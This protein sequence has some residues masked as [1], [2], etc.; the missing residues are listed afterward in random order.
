[1]VKSDHFSNII[2][3]ID[4]TSLVKEQNQSRKNLITE[5]NNIVQKSDEIKSQNE[6][7]EIVNYLDQLIY[8]AGFSK[9]HSLS[10]PN[11]E[12]MRKKIHLQILDK[13]GNGIQ[14][15]NIYAKKQIY[16]QK[17]IAMI[18]EALKINHDQS[19]EKALH[20]FN[21]IIKKNME[22]INKGLGEFANFEKEYIEERL[23]KYIDGID[24]FKKAKEPDLENIEITDT[25]Y[26][27]IKKILTKYV[28]ESLKINIENLYH[29]NFLNN[30]NLEDQISIFA[31]HVLQQYVGA[32]SHAKNACE[33][34]EFINVYKKNLI[35]DIQTND[36]NP[37]YISRTTNNNKQILHFAMSDE[38]ISD[39][40]KK[41]DII[42]NNLVKTSLLN[43]MDEYFLRPNINHSLNMSRKLDNDLDYFLNELNTLTKELT[44]YE[45]KL[46]IFH[47][48]PRS[49][50]QSLL[51][52]IL[53]DFIFD[54]E[55]HHYQ[56]DTFLKTGI[57][58]L[59]ECLYQARHANCDEDILFNF[60]YA[61]RDIIDQNGVNLF[62]K[63]CDQKKTNDEQLNILAKGLNNFLDEINSVKV[64]YIPNKS[65]LDMQNKFFVKPNSS[66]EKMFLSSNDYL[67]R[68]WQLITPFI[69]NETD[70]SNAQNN[71]NNL[72]IGCKQLAFAA[73]LGSNEA[74]NELSL[75]SC[76]KLTTKK[77]LLAAD[78]KFYHFLKA[79][80][81]TSIHYNDVQKN[82]ALYYYGLK[83][84]KIYDNY[85]DR[86][87]DILLAMTHLRNVDASSLTN[88]NFL[89]FLKHAFLLN[90]DKFTQEEIENNAFRI[91][92]DELLG[93]D[94][95]R[96]TLDEAASVETK[97]EPTYPFRL[98]KD[99]LHNLLS[100][101]LKDTETKN[102]IKNEVLHNIDKTINSKIET[103]SARKINYSSY[104]ICINSDS[105][106]NSASKVI[107]FLDPETS[108]E[109]AR[110]I[111][112]DKG[113][114][115]DCFN[116]DVKFKI[117]GTLEGDNFEIENVKT[118]L[119]LEVNLKSGKNLCFTTNAP[120]MVFDGE[121]NCDSLQINCQDAIL[122]KNA[123]FAVNSLININGKELSIE[124]K[125]N[126]N[127]CF[128][129][130]SGS[131]TQSSTSTIHAYN[132]INV[133]ALSLKGIE[134]KIDAENK[135]N[136]IADSCVYLKRS[137][138]LKAKEH[139][140]IQATSMLTT[141]ESKLIAE[142][143]L[144]LKAKDKIIADEL[145]N[146]IAESLVVDAKTI[147]NFSPNL[148]FANAD[149]HFENEFRNFS[150]GIFNTKNYLKLSGG[151]VWNGGQIKYGENLYAN[152]NRVFVHG[153]SSLHSTSYDDHHEEGYWDCLKNK[154][155]SNGS[156]ISGK[157]AVIVAGAYINILGLLT[158][159]DFTFTGLGEINFGAAASLNSNKNALISLD[160]GA[161]VPNIKAYATEIAQFIEDVNNGEYE[162]VLSSICN[163]NNLYKL[164]SC[165]KWFI[166]SIFPAL[167][168]PIN[169][170][171]SLLI[172]I[173]NAPN[174]FK[175]IYYLYQQKENLQ[176]SQIYELV[177]MINAVT[178]HS[179]LLGSELKN[180][181]NFEFDYTPNFK[182]APN[183][184]LNF[185]SLFL[186]SAT[187]Q[188]L[189]D[190][191]LGSFNLSGNIQNNNLF[192][193]SLWDAEIA[194]TIANMFYD[195]HLK[196]KLD[197]A[198]LLSNSGENLTKS[199]LAITANDIS[200]V[201]NR[202]DSGHI[203]T[204]NMIWKG[205]ELELKEKSNIDTKDAILS[206]NKLK[207]SGTVNAD[208][209][210][211]VGEH[212]MKV[213]GDINIKQDKNHVNTN[214]DHSNDKLI[215]PE[216]ILSAPNIQQNKN[217]H[218][219]AQK[220]TTFL[221]SQNAR[222]SGENNTELYANVK[223]ELN[224]DGKFT[225]PGLHVSADK[226]VINGDITIP[227][228]KFDEANRN[229]EIQP[230]ITI[231]GNELDISQ[232]TT[233]K[234]PDST[235]V[236]DEQ[237]ISA[238]GNINTSKIYS[239]GNRFQKYS[240]SLLVDEM[241]V[242]GD[243]INSEADIHF[244]H[245]N[246]EH[247]FSADA[248]SIFQMTQGSIEGDGTVAIK[249][250]DA[251]L[252][253]I[254]VNNLAFEFDHIDNI[255]NLITCSGDYS[256]LHPRKGIFIA[257]TDHVDLKKDFDLPYSATIAA[258][259][260]D[261]T[262]NIHSSG[263]LGFI[264]KNKDIKTTQNQINADG[265]IYIDSHGKYIN[266]KGD[267][268][269]GEL[270]IHTQDDA[271]NNAGIWRS[272]LYVEIN[273]DQGNIINRCYEHDVQGKY[274]VVKA[275]EP[276][277]IFGG[278]GNNHA[279]V[280]LNMHAGNKIV[281]DASVI[282][283]LGDNSI[284]GDKGIE[285]FARY[286][287]YLSYYKHW[288]NIWREKTTKEYSTQIQPA[289]IS[290]LQGKN[291]LIS[292]DG[293]IH[294]VS[295]DFF[296]PLGHDLYAK[297]DIV[298]EGIIASTECDK[299]Q[300]G[301]F[302]ITH[303]NTKQYDEYAV[304]T[305]MVDLADSRIV[306]NSDIKIT[307]AFISGPGDLYL[308]GK[309]VFISSPILNHSFKEDK[310][311]FGIKL[312]TL[313]SIPGYSIYKDIDS[314]LSAKHVGILTNMWNTGVDAVLAANNAIN[315][316]RTGNVS[317]YGSS[318]LPELTLTHSK[319][320]INE[321]SVAE[322]VG[323]YKDSLHI[324]ADDNV[325][326][327]NG[328]TV[329]IKN[330]ASIKSKNFLQSG[331]QLQ[332]SFTSDSQEL[333]FG[334]SL[335]GEPHIGANVSGT[336]VEGKSY[337]NQSF[338][339]GNQLSIDVDNW[340]M[341]AAN[342]NSKCIAGKVGKFTITSPL[343]TSSSESYGAHFDTL[344]SMGANYSTDSKGWIGI[345]SGLNV[346]DG[347]NI[348]GDDFN[349][350]HLILE[351][352]KIM[353]DGVNNFH[354]D[355][356][357]A[358]DVKGYDERFSFGFDF[359]ANDFIN[360]GNNH[361][362][363]YN[364]N[365]GYKDYQDRQLGTIFGKQGTHIN[366]NSIMGNIISDNGEGIKIDK[367]VDMDINIKIPAFNKKNITAMQDNFDWLLGRDNEPIIHHSIDTKKVDTEKAKI[368]PKS[369]VKDESEKNNDVV[370]NQF[371][372]EELS[373]AVDEINS[374][375]F[376]L[377]HKADDMVNDLSET[378]SEFR[379]EQQDEEQFRQEVDDAIHMP[380]P[381]VKLRLDDANFFKPSSYNFF[382]CNDKNNSDWSQFDYDL[383]HSYG[384]AKAN[385]YH[386]NESYITE[387]YNDASIS[388]ELNVDFA[389]SRYLFHPSYE[390]N[391]TFTLPQY[392]PY[393]WLTTKELGNVPIY[394]VN[395]E[396]LLDSIYMGQGA[397]TTSWGQVINNNFW[398]T[399]DM[400]NSFG[401]GFGEALFFPVLYPKETIEG[402]FVLGQ[403]NNDMMMSVIDEEAR[404]RVVEAG[405]LL[406]KSAKDFRAELFSDDKNE[407]YKAC[408]TA[409]GNIIP[410][411]GL[412][413]KAGLFGKIGKAGRLV[414]EEGVANL[415]SK[416]HISG[417]RLQQQL[418][419]EEASSIFNES[420]FL[421]KEAIDSAKI[422]AR[423]D[424]LGNEELVN[425]LLQKEGNLSDWG[426]YRTP[427]ID[428]PSGRFEMHFYKNS[429]T[430]E[431][432]YERDYKAVFEHQG[433]WN[434]EPTPNFDYEP[435]RYNK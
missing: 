331:A 26:S 40:Y 337:Q 230:E 120:K 431:V 308:A 27:Y 46:A 218:I 75:N 117:K 68:Y 14:I 62:L 334:I 266:E 159:N 9:T 158:L 346:K 232:G 261:I 79:C 265:V 45:L 397:T 289:I 424:K 63:L 329:D 125:L 104:A 34:Q 229:K 147:K 134:G 105:I 149:L 330:D 281:N 192:S 338:N 102:K 363:I 191:R 390:Q 298:L 352:G 411:G 364:V 60:N 194:L 241:T 321:Q 288:K 92:L 318:L 197:I 409:A 170:L 277:C 345:P 188:A 12:L 30:D 292:N 223:N 166:G 177:G 324:V 50:A 368:N 174:I 326:F 290:S 405:K 185:A 259:S 5:I 43:K 418:K 316:A 304:P 115:I 6:L 416:N 293:G 213:E 323:I 126:S 67:M 172:I 54:I 415:A 224:L 138:R 98:S 3:H 284:S 246:Q 99:K 340:E 52:K 365:F 263:S 248:N 386:P 15:F 401:K 379:R 315:I 123:K 175:Q 49:E 90:N 391:N 140:A 142:K 413:A 426:K 310:L 182:N 367:D 274:D 243:V 320:K 389:N 347:I 164:A 130:L 325:E 254:N 111:K 403:L 419:M 48:K 253:H 38:C 257:T 106:K 269:G 24:I 434:L 28:N 156:C 237:N 242:K 361:I 58:Y 384:R 200:N 61:N 11:V 72:L 429:V 42:E 168:K 128:I 303:D 322:N 207:L 109:V 206:Q 233:I 122:E 152:L 309:N 350:G 332:H 186:P 404:Q 211:A 203:I 121:I 342:T 328:C 96:E 209:F 272:P 376:D 408:G 91:L 32:L 228:T 71:I 73:L 55:P 381:D 216:L 145:S 295:T 85:L 112:E 262:A 349:V 173:S 195:D 4:V 372:D 275:Y 77:A 307:N 402:I 339:V 336:N 302:G 396:N 423:G 21:Q 356:I 301:W 25:E 76:E 148:Y 93:E 17:C 202:K 297:N 2:P 306:S 256:D 143:A 255:D 369:K 219:N 132:D 47:F 205:D 165:I 162:K 278:S 74:K 226:T 380:L 388:P 23:M 227:E 66:E 296:A 217:S 220:A 88:D 244:K 312:P 247:Y 153:I 201:N 375:D 252:G 20:D 139:L 271:V 371:E 212:D 410:I 204:K 181:R 373:K 37:D 294:S 398:D 154:V 327:K 387:Q 187:K 81:E 383:S 433:R 160:L 407:R 7:D 236:I 208:H 69:K 428:S 357:E 198:Y 97:S 110:I 264:S 171:W 59:V 358:K 87:N 270:Y 282:Y 250:P 300:T 31:A 169:M 146:W 51:R 377:S 258:D 299:K 64:L 335:D 348:N 317:S 82:L 370:I 33:L 382:G 313:E 305:Y 80:P 163:H 44:W 65:K 394:D 374:F 176:P 399:I 136:V 101:A 103:Y 378:N 70:K 412:L 155:N 430:G 311:D 414:G 133:K 56:K 89:K 116:N 351:G 135:L 1:M 231:F 16:L 286:H 366:T 291:T 167:G 184:A 417:L 57:S 344:G 283:S 18:E 137:G 141:G 108:E 239:Q 287:K 260:F 214:S 22:E 94:P 280:G 432:Y 234:A 36:K 178:P 395:R 124:G 400:V 196:S 78:E 8:S 100:I 355:T 222:L 238:A 127:D 210:V 10:E 183:F 13:L 314:L 427:L 131:L 360:E 421:N 95:L 39:L 359:N 157:K 180:I 273:A 267:I 19:Y 385:E 190:A 354:A 343:N 420:G 150:T 129:D 119:R 341:F 249:A 240:G 41:F 245:D 268:C 392:N 151:S 113:F 193:Y 285:S 53:E 362:P 199:G 251:K 276:G 333:S 221:Q 161:N 84:S 225:G 35:D 189:L 235:I 83:Y 29:K 393:D 86:Y 319:I 406:F 422:I 353:T 107:S 114:Y 425:E 179:V 144:Y 435:P 118:D 215:H 279:G